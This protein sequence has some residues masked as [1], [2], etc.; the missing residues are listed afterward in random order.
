MN[1]GID[2]ERHDIEGSRDSDPHELSRKRGKIN[3][4]SH[5]T[6]EKSRRGTLG[7]F[8]APDLYEDEKPH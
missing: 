5:E 1:N 6:L 4:L 2:S 8:P 3:K 7:T